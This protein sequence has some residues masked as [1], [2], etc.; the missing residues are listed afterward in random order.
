M[1]VNTHHGPPT[2]VRGIVVTISLHR[3]IAL[4]A[5]HHVGNFF[6]CP[7]L[8]RIKLS[9]SAS[10]LVRVDSFKW[11]ST[12]E[13]PQQKFVGRIMMSSKDTFNMAVTGSAVSRNP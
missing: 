5:L 7:G 6:V 3:T 1:L 12:L 10:L 8:T 9:P 13:A 4:N 11:P 2:L